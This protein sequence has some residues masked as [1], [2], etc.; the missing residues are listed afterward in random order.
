M[1]LGRSIGMLILIWT[2]TSILSVDLA[3][4][5]YLAKFFEGHMSIALFP[6]AFFVMAA[7]IASL[8]GTA[9]GTI[10]MLI[11]LALQMLLA[12]LGYTGPV[13]LGEIPMCFP[14]LGAIV[15]GS[16]I[17]NHISPISDVILISSTSAGAYHLDLVKAQA[18]MV[19]P[20][21]IASI[22]AFICV[23]SMIAHHYSLWVSALAPLGLGM[24]LIMAQYHALQFWYDRQL[25]KR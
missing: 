23:G 11:P 8:M 18:S 24:A 13:V 3:T 14:L 16:I 15:S 12:F 10:G 4:G 22:A 21:I 19:V 17:G 9:W 6:V 7:V 20:I 25:A 2:L 1:L 5:Q